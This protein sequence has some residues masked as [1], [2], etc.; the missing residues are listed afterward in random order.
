LLSSFW[1]N[2][3]FDVPD[4]VLK[5]ILAFG[6]IDWDEK[7]KCGERFFGKAAMFRRVTKQSLCSIVRTR[8]ASQG[9]GRYMPHNQF[10][11][12]NGM[13][14]YKMVDLNFRPA[15]VCRGNPEA[16]KILHIPQV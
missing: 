13:A 1:I 4:N 12:H 16:I 15:V 5:P 2:R 6:D 3:I 9:S 11:K 14:K 10:F 8:N 7:A